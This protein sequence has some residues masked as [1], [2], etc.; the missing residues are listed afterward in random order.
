MKNLQGHEDGFI[1]INWRGKSF[2]I[3]ERYAEG[4]RNYL[5]EEAGCT[6][7]E[8]SDITSEKLIRDVPAIESIRRLV[9]LEEMWEMPDAK[10]DR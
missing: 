2:T 1:Y 4:L 3:D 9:Q 10:T 8:V 5:V 7:Q 6:P